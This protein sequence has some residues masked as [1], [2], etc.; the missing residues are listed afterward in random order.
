MQNCWVTAF[1]ATRFAYIFIHLRQQIGIALLK[2]LVHEIDVKT[3]K[4]P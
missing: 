4:E 2:G 3:K 1:S